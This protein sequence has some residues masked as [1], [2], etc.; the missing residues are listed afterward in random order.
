MKAGLDILE[1]VTGAVRPVSQTPAVERRAHVVRLLRSLD[2]AVALWRQLQADGR[3]SVFQRVEAF[4]AWAQTIAPAHGAEWFVAAVLDGTTHAPL[5]LLPLTRV[6]HGGLTFIEAADLGVCDFNGPVAAMRFQPSLCE[7]K[8]IWAEIRGLL[9]AADILRLTKMPDE[10]GG[11]P[12]PLLQ[13]RAAHKIKLS[14]FKTP[15]QTDEQPWSFLSLPE[16]LRADLSARM[17]KLSKRGTVE[18]RVAET[19]AEAN[20]YFDAMVSQR[21]AR[22]SA[23]GRS[24]ILDCPAHQ[25]FY[26]RLLTLGSVA[27]LGCIQALLLDGEVIATGYGLLGQQGFAMIFPTFRAEGLR[28][29]S[30]GM[31]LF[32]ESMQWASRKGL[33]YYDFTIGGEEFKLTLGAQEFPLFEH[34]EALSL[35]GLPFVMKERMRR[36]V[37]NSR[38]KP[39]AERAQRH[40]SVFLSPAKARP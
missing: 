4:E 1:H 7:M 33:A 18:F 14:N 13:L 8:A 40:L 24:N 6:R 15:L 19:S 28:N 27:G 3:S 9:P 2:E 25:R 5:M 17:R 11:L 16:K 21:A 12:N 32:V 30:P 39:A 38:L 26:R 36:R 20:R 22:C 23:M 31:L 10:I 29:Y 34:L 37:A 35:R